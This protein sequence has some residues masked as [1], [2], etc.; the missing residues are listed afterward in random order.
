MNFHTDDTIRAE[1]EYRREQLVRA[2]PRRRR[3]KSLKEE[4]RMTPAPPEL[5][6]EDV[7]PVDTA[8][9]EHDGRELSRY[10]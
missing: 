8:A 10:D 9:P 2:W 6:A 4:N 5:S 7:G 1:V 3:H